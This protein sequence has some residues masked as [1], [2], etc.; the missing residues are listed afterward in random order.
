M[1]LPSDHL[2]TEL[3]RLHHGFYAMAR[4]FREFSATGGKY[5]GA[6]ECADMAAYFE[7]KAV[8]LAE[9]LA[10]HAKGLIA[11]APP[12][13]VASRPRLVVRDGEVLS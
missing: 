7:G 5:L 4:T 12:P 9:V 11:L 6:A 10:H 13:V 8:Y 3:E 2:T 1:A